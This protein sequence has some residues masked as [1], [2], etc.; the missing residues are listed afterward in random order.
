MYT[1]SVH[2]LTTQTNELNKYTLNIEVNMRHNAVSNQQQIENPTLT[3]PSYALTC[4]YVYKFKDDN[5]QC[6]Q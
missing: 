2:T 4:N 5:L 3:K 1:I 6:Y